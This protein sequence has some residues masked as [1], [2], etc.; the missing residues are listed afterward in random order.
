MHDEHVALFE[1]I[2]EGEAERNITRK[3]GGGM[4]K[5]KLFTGAG[6]PHIFF[7]NPLFCAD[8]FVGYEAVWEVL[9]GSL[10]E[11]FE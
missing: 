2:R 4:S 5:V 11:F 9:I 6:S 8:G 1:S 10:V 3:S 7:M